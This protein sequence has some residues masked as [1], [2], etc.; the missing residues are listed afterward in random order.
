MSMINPVGHQLSQPWLSHEQMARQDVSQHVRAGQETSVNYAPKAVEWVNMNPV[1]E[2]KEKKKVDEK[3]HPDKQ[4]CQTCQKRRYQDGSNDPGVSFKAAQHLSPETAGSA[5]RA[6]ESEHVSRNR[7]KAFRENKE[8]VYQQV[9]I[10]TD[11]CPECGRVY[12]SGGTTTTVTRDQPAQQTGR[13]P[14][15][16]PGEN[17]DTHA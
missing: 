17:L 1:N 15:A 4:P 11:I 3:N 12:V 13:Q 2:A 7:A 14:F 6:H 9:A 5:V 16:I 10:H 8:I